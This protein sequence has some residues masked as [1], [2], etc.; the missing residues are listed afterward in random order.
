MAAT[1]PRQ[2]SRAP[3][4]TLVRARY[5]VC[6]GRK[7]RPPCQIV[8]TSKYSKLTEVAIAAS[9]LEAHRFVLV[10]TSGKP[11][12]A[13]SAT[14]LII[15]KRLDNRRA[16]AIEEFIS[17]QFGQVKVLR[18][19]LVVVEKPGIQKA[20]VSGVLFYAV[21][22]SKNDTVSADV[23]NFLYP[24]LNEARQGVSG[25]VLYSTD[26]DRVSFSGTNAFLA[27]IRFTER[28]NDLAGSSRISLPMR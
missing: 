7:R 13:P 11:Y 9:K 27:K 6:V 2:A 25:N 4:P 14:T 16:L 10:G 28:A 3:G 20:T 22:L 5:R 18:L 15:D 24:W 12:S 26:S 1:R 19:P 17:R 23:A 8:S 21:H